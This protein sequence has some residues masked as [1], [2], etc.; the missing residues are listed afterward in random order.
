MTQKQQ[1]DLLYS[2]RSFCAKVAEMCCFCYMKGEALLFHL[3]LTLAS[4]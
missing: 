2:S 4:F 1:F 3:K